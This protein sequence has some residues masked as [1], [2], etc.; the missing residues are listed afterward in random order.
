MLLGRDAE[1]LAIDRLLAE[2]REG[3]SGV[4][5]LA[6]EPG[7]GKTALLDYAVDRGGEMRVLR[8][9]G[10]ESE[11]EVPFAGLAELLRPAL[12][13]IN[14]I[15]APQAAALAGALALAPATAQD[16]FA[17]GAAALSLLSAHAD[18]GPLLLVVDDAHLLDPSSAEALLFAARRLVADPIAVLIAAREGEPS[19]LDGADL[20]VLRVAGLDRSQASELLA[21]A[22]V[23]AEAAERLYLAT[24]GNPLALLELAPEAHRIAATPATGPVPIS[25]SIAAAF[26]RRSESLSAPARRLLVLAAASDTGDLA[27]L[28]RAARALDLD[29]EE[30]AAAEEVGLVR[31]DGGVVEFRHPLARS[32]LYAGAS[33]TERRAAHAAL[34][35]ALPDRD[36]DRRA[37]HLA[38][39]TVGPDDGAAAALEQAGVRA[40]ERSAYAVAAAAFERAAGLSTVDDR[41]ANRLFSAA[42]AAWLGGDGERTLK[43]IEAARMHA[44][45]RMLLARIDQL[46]GRIQ[47]ERGPV[48]DGYALIVSAADRIARGDPDL[49]A[50]MLSEAVLASFYAGDTP[51]MLKAAARAR[52]LARRNGSRRASSFAAMAEGMALIA[53]GQGEAGAAAVRRAVAVLETSDDLRDDPRLLAWAS[54]GPLWLREAEAGR[55][56]MER[57]SERARDLA[58]VGLLPTLLHHLARDQ[59]TTDQWAAAAASYDEGIRLARETGQRTAL[60]A[61]LAGLA[62]LEARQGREASCRAHAAEAARLCAELGMATYEVWTIQALGD[63]E[64]G[65]ARPAAALEHYRAQAEALHVRGIADIDL[66]PGP[67]LVDVHLRLGDTPSAAAAADEFAPRAEEKGQPWALAR[68][69]RSRGLLAAGDEMEAWFDEALRLHARTPDVFEQARTRL[70]YGASLRRARK[71]VRAREELRAALQVF[72]A[73][74]AQ[75]WADQ[76]SAELAATGETARRRDASTLDDLTPQELQIARLLA[77]GKTTREAAAAV[78]LSPKTVEYHLRNVYR[79]LGIAS[80]DELSRVSL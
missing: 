28:A 72:D 58:E 29:V 12:G 19:L 65:L 3:R 46:H 71:R 9:R 6:G 2:A 37:W 61:A 15:P 39:A 78:F 54:L 60:T 24:G 42:D 57:A 13:A 23:P 7:I 63:L 35:A 26:T 49:A 56:L 21:G 62:W 40:R 68:A 47:I 4:L 36:V 16:R 64:L 73:L 50:E 43:L 10:I 69:A 45:D 11:A 44:Y 77:D 27:L 55:A 32:A 1:R 66:S 70:A 5:A 30:L 52:T 33:G 41:R 53:D 79:K 75:P 17:T 74:G 48:M 80:R 76:A 25:T 51:A 31:L 18:D 67:E 38:S 22:D 20:R 34:A 8:A 14:R 59:C